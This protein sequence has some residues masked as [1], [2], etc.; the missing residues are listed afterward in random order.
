D[1]L[2]WYGH[3]KAVAGEVNV[4]AVTDG[5]AVLIVRVDR[6][7]LPDLRRPAGEEVAQ[8]DGDRRRG[9]RIRRVVEVL[10]DDHDRERAVRGPGRGEGADLVRIG[11]GGAD[12]RVTERLRA[13]G[14]IAVH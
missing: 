1:A 12:A 5:G 7:Q 3:R 10:V 13:A 6:R 9:V 14:V 8:V 2:L 4:R 11:D